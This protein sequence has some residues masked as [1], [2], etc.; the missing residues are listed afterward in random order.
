MRLLLRNIL[1]MVGLLWAVL[2]RV[3]PALA[4]MLAPIQAVQKATVKPDTKTTAVSTES[5]YGWVQ[6]E[7]EQSHSV[8]DSELLPV[9]ATT[10]LLGLLAVV[11][12]LPL[13]LIFPRNPTS[14]SRPYYLLYCSLRI[15][16]A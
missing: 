9:G 3:T 5:A 7:E 14:V 2:F 12:S 1:L 13:L 15:P 16:E 10:W 4:G 11:L 6:D 8:I